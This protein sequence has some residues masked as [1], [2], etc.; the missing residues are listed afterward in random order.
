MPKKIKELK[1]QF[2]SLVDRPANN[3]PVQVKSTL[4][5]RGKNRFELELAIRNKSVREGLLYGVVYEPG[6]VDLQNEWADEGAILKAAHAFLRYAYQFNVDL[7]H[8]FNA[9]K[10][11]VVESF[12]LNGADARF[13]NTKA[14]AW[15]VVIK[16][17]PEAIELIDEIN[18][19]SLAGYVQYD[20]DAQPPKKHNRIINNYTNMIPTNK[21]LG[22]AVRRLRVAADR[23][24]KQVAAAL[25]IEKVEDYLD[26]ESGKSEYEFTEASLNAFAKLVKQSPAAVAIALM[27]DGAP[28][29]PNAD[30]D[31]A[32][33]PNADPMMTPEADPAAGKS[34]KTPKKNVAAKSAPPQDDADDE[35]KKTAAARKRIRPTVATLDV[36]DAKKHTGAAEERKIG[37][38][39][40]SVGGA[41]LKSA[42]RILVEKG[43][44]EK[45]YFSETDF[46]YGDTLHPA[47]GTDLISVAVDQ[48]PFM[49][50]VQV[51]EMQSLQEMVPVA[52]V[53]DGGLTLLTAGAAVGSTLNN[54]TVNLSKLLY[55]HEVDYP[56]F[57]PFVVFDNYRGNLPGLQNKL[58]DLSLLNYGNQLLRLGMT[59]TTDTFNG[60]AADPSL[61]LSKGWYQ[62]AVEMATAA[63]QIV[64]FSAD[65]A[66]GNIIDALDLM[67]GNMSANKPQHAFAPTMSIVMGP[68]DFQKFETEV[69]GLVQPNE[70]TLLNGAKRLYRGKSIF[71]VPYLETQKIFLTKIENFIFGF[72]TRGPNGA[73]FQALEKEKGIQNI[74]SSAVDYEFVDYTQIVYSKA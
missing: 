72:V 50:Q 62:R 61:T 46:D 2:I 14:G 5:L 35:A 32:E 55:C 34:A 42:E 51:I 49:K 27:N 45:D 64:D 41:I 18:G 69:I 73:R 56:Y 59:G 36:K 22:E 71:V 60:L 58:S 13:P 25:G 74:L 28:A 40:K 17:S 70:G 19:I 6:T 20:E 16:L 30:D 47:L 9:G 1:V 37:E 21:S 7:N 38:I 12:I 4:D 23:S 10:G 53:S 48:S 57:F 29:D 31:P 33:D 54:K 44:V 11:V 43:F 52:D 26:F 3:K 67:I 15:C 8:D 39:K 24:E 63:W 68:E 66:S 65:V